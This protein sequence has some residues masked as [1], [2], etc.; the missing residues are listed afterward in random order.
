M[1]ALISPPRP[2]LVRGGAMNGMIPSSIW[3]TLPT[4]KSSAEVLGTA[5]RDIGFFV[6]TGH[7]I[8]DTGRRGIC[9]ISDFSPA[10]RRTKP[11]FPSSSRATI[12]AMSHS[13]KSGLTPA[14][15]AT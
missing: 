4:T 5:A 3:R 13:V 1:G 11:R 6:V 2:P 14:N 9:A 15:P 12:A 10:T 8:A 7:G